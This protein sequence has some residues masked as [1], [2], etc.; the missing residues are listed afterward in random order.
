MVFTTKPHLIFDVDETGNSN[1][2]NPPQILCQKNTN[3]QT[4]TSPRY[5]NVT[6]IGCGNASG[7]FIPPYYIFPEK[8]WSADFLEGAPHGSSGECTDS[9]W[10]NMFTFQNDL[11]ICKSSKS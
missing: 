8:R 6:V 4:I 7:N 1:E 9:G 11:E 2:H 5:S 3:V 10:S